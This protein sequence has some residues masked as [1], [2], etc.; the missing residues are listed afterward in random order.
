VDDDAPEFGKLTMQLVF[1]FLFNAVNFRNCG[2][3]AHQKME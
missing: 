2:A 1:H 3:L